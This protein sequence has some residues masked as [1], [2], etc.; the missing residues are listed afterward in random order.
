MCYNI[1]YSLCML[2]THTVCTQWKLDN[3]TLLLMCHGSAYSGT[4]IIG[5]ALNNK[6]ILQSFVGLLRFIGILSF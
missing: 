3:L 6:Y 1:R 2:G 4:L 5:R